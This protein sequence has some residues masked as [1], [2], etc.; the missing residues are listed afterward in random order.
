MPP[1]D[2][3]ML[4]QVSESSTAYMQWSRT[5]CILADG[6][7]TYNVSSGYDEDERS[8][9]GNGYLKPK[10]IES[11]VEFFRN[12]RLEMI[13][14]QELEE[15]DT[16]TV[17]EESS[18]TFFLMPTHQEVVLI[19]FNAVSPP[20]EQEIYGLSW[21]AEEPAM[22]QMKQMNEFAERVLALAPQAP[23][24]PDE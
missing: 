5:V 14:P 3:S 12:N 2:S 1:D 22:L 19:K 23:G 7:F 16:K 17:E 6:R 8:I 21:R 15:S 24:F 4:I 9:E 10:E 11:L 20:Y 13:G 18:S